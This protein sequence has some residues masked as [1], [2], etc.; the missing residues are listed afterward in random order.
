MNYGTPFIVQSR[1]NDDVIFDYETSKY[2]FQQPYFSTKNSYGTAILDPKR[3]QGFLRTLLDFQSNYNGIQKKHMLLNKKLHNNQ[4][5]KVE[6]FPLLLSSGS[7]QNYTLGTGDEGVLALRTMLDVK[8]LVCNLVGGGLLDKGG[9]DGVGEHDVHKDG[10]DGKG[11]KRKHERNVVVSAA[12]RVL[13]R[14]SDRV[15]GVVVTANTTRSLSMQGSKRKQRGWDNST[16]VIGTKKQQSISDDD[17]DEEDEGNLCSNLKGTASFVDWLS[18]PLR[19]KT[20]E[21]DNDVEAVVQA[22][23]KESIS[24]PDLSSSN[25]DGGTG[26]NY[27]SSINKTATTATLAATLEEKDSEDSNKDDDEDDIEDGFIAL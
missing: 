21:T 1:N 12:E 9:G 26:N 5:G 25:N 27:T 16:C 4:K 24:V 23:K 18:E 19:K 22:S 15:L 11:S 7:R 6:K 8:S 10:E 20:N 3:R 2:L 13:A 17:S 14:A